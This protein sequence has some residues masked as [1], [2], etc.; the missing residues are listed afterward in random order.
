MI[1]LVSVSKRL[2]LVLVTSCLL[3]GALAGCLGEDDV[4]VTD[5]V[6]P[7][8]EDA[9][10]ATI[11]EGGALEPREMT[12][13]LPT[14]L[15]LTNEDTEARSFQGMEQK[16]PKPDWVPEPSVVDPHADHK[17]NPLTPIGPLTIQPGET[18]VLGDIDYH[19]VLMMMEVEDMDNFAVWEILPASG[20]TYPS[21]INQVI[22]SGATTG[23]TDA[24]GADSYDLVVAYPDLTTISLDLR[25]DD[26]TDDDVGGSST[27]GEDELELR[28]YDPAGELVESRKA[29]G[30]AEGVR[31]SHDITIEPFP[32]EVEAVGLSNATAKMNEERPGDMTH[33]GTW[34]IEVA[35]L[36]APGLVPDEDGSTKDLPSGDGHQEWTLSIKTVHKWAAL[37]VPDAKV[38]PDLVEADL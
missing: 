26:A 8:C 4:E 28:L 25:W 6:Y 18:Q 38:S 16:L 1:P 35:V 12:L 27:N 13:S 11:L 7:G 20:Q 22:L 5:D 10:E 37:K 24:G 30:R 3:G 32:T 33:A 21:Y 2:A 14:T 29:T 23:D 15:C 9:V 36:S 17:G 19:G 31:Y 34:K